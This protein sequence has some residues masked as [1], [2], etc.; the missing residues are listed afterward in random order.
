M[1]NTKNK[2]NSLNNLSASEILSYMSELIAVKT[3][4]KT[5]SRLNL[6]AN[7][8]TVSISGLGKMQSKKLDVRKGI[9][10]FVEINWSA[11]QFL[12]SL[13]TEANGEA[14]TVQQICRSTKPAYSF[15]AYFEACGTLLNT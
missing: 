12:V 11:N 9:K 1:S 13:I 6:N 7:D 10:K 15:A 4:S 5:N 2:S 14:V 3:P 8:T